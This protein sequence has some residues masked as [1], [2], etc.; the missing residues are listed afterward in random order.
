MQR[1]VTTCWLLVTVW[2]WA[3]C[4]AASLDSQ[5]RALLDGHEGKAAVAI[6]HLTT[7]EQFTFRENETMP[8]ASLIKLA[9][10][11]ETYRQAE[12]GRV[13]LDRRITLKDEDKVAGSGILTPHFSAGSQI[14]LRD[15]V[16]LMIAYSD[17][18]ATN[19]VL[20][21]IGI[22]STSETMEKLGFP[23]TKIH[24]QVFRRE[25]SV[26]P[27]RS[28][29]FGLGSTTASETIGL[30]EQLYRAKLAS[31]TSTQA[32]L[33]HLEACQDRTKLPRLLNPQIRIAHKTGSVSR[34]RADAGLL[35]APSGPIAICVLTSDNKDRRWTDENAGDVLCAKVAEVAFH[36]FNPA[37]D[38]TAAA[39]LLK[40]GDN[41]RT[42]E[43]LQRTLN[44]RLKPSS[45][46]AIDGDFGPNTR[47][48][49][50][51]F[52]REH[53]LRASGTADAD[54]WKALGPLI[55]EDAL[56]VAP[57]VFNREVLATQ[58]ADPLDGPPHV[59]CKA[60]AIGDHQSGKLLWH[61]DANRRL[62]IAS[63]TKMMTAYIVLTL[64]ARDPDVL[65]D[66][67]V[68]SPQADQTPGSSAR[69]R[70]GEELSVGELLYGL[71]L[72][73]G[74]DAAIALSEHFGS[75]FAPPVGAEQPSDATTRFIAEM[76]RTAEALQMTATTFRNPHGLTAKGH[77]G[78]A[79]DLVKLA[80]V[81]M[82]LPEFRLRV[83][84]RQHG[85]TVTGPGGYQRNVLWK[86][87][88]R[89]LPI[90]G[91]VGIKTGTTTAAGACLVSAGQRGKDGLFVVVLGSRSSSARYTD[92]RNLYRWAWQQRKNR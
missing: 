19:L 43:D 36:H 64:A 5:L 3:P 46:L 8:T 68:F 24:A 11:I 67:V 14:S 74:N 29:Q 45:D 27:N 81:A 56:Q 57:G 15:A 88:N 2:V 55:T 51:R 31:P 65:N 42:V 20:N 32:M 75:G 48:A 50:R 16:Q 91:Y 80:H 40:I 84:T 28:R 38:V 22:K 86:N 83:S 13:D 44:A 1:F 61:H 26:F 78:T 37:G 39:P 66:K 23:N 71:L 4:S 6:K 47:A 35:F 77:H 7:G 73:S 21:Q 69:I 70:T 79:H 62:D 10:M 18:T 82:K 41:G 60:W 25:T 12:T 17:N 54:T 72:P 9:V 34:V 89:L 87:T 58:P 63:T 76:N 92:T 59:T 85:V 30:L 49:L 90:D 33:T 53:Q 52:Q